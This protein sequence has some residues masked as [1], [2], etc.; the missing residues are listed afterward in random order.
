MGRGEEA[1]VPSW[2]DWQLALG[3]RGGADVCNLSEPPCQGDV[4]RGAVMVD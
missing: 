3:R 4:P 2:A 1:H